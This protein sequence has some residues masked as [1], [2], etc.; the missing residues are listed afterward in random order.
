MAG[1]WGKLGDR[2]EVGRWG[3]VRLEIE[4]RDYRVWESAVP[5]EM[6]WN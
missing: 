3:G 2:V 5:S 4:R 1:I 6:A